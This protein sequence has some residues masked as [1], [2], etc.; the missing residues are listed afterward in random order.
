MILRIVKE[1][2]AI[3]RHKANRVDQVT[4]EIKKLA[5]NMIETM[6]AA[7][8]VGLAANQVGSP[9]N[10]F[11]AN[12]GNKRGEELILLN[13]VITHR[14]GEE[15]SPE[16]CLSLPGISSPVTRAAEVTLT[17]MTL[18][19]EK[20]TL[21]AKGFLAK[22]FQHEIDHLEGR[23]Y[24]ERLPAAEGKHLLAKYQKLAETLRRVD[25]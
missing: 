14:A 7:E 22:I 6:Y 4:P 12:P 16:G 3:L 19:N 2:H 15:T 20:V 18:L 25:L 21:Q 11:V 9:L 1:P 17:G 5:A 10:L 24:P 8:G 23:L 13:A